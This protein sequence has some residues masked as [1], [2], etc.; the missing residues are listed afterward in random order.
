MLR[1]AAGF[2]KTVGFNVDAMQRAA[3]AGFMNA[4]AA[5]GFLSKQGVPFRDAH[6]KIG[7]AVR[8][9]VEKKCEIE[10]LSLDELK[11]C[12]IDFGE[13]FYSSLNLTAVIACHNVEGGTAPDD[14][15][16]ALASAKQKLTKEGMASH[17]RA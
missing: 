8:L 4:M 6:E 10:D 2:M 3:S 15:R 17:A 13:T 5:A 14:V 16:R 11:H 9:C 12:G 7:A 1:V